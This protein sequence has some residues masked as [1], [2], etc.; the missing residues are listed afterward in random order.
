MLIYKILL[1][2]EWAAFE[3]AGEFAGSEF[4]R[5]DGFVHCSTRAQAPATAA[6]FFAGV[7]ELVLVALDDAKLDSEVRWEEASAGLFPHVYGPLTAGAI[8]AVHRVA[9]ASDVDA[10]LPPD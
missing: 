4:D 1:P 10:A 7:P 6:R 2:A 5:A 9:G 8:T 3:A